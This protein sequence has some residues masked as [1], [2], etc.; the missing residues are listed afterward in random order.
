MRRA[1]PKHSPAPPANCD[2]CPNSQ[3]CVFILPQLLSVCALPSSQQRLL[4]LIKGF[5]SEGHEHPTDKAREMDGA[6]EHSVGEH[7]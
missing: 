5:P 6:L 1:F 2:V 3:A 7:S 4:D